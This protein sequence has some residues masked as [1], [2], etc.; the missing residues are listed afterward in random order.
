[1]AEKNDGGDKTEKPTPKRLSDAR[2]KGDVPKSKDVTSTVVL[3]AW[4]LLGLMVA[5]VTLDRLGGLFDEIFAVI[6]RPFAQAWPIAGAAAGRALVT[7]TATLLIPAAI[8]GM[9][10]EFA[11]VGPVFTLEKMTPKM[12]H[13]NPGEGLKRM[14]NTDNLFEVVKSLAKTVLLVVLTWIVAAAAFD[15]LMAVPTGEADGALAA[16]GGLTFQLLAGTVGVFLF[17]SM[18]DYAYQKF[19]FTKKMRMSRRDIRQEMKDSE[20]DPHVKAHRRQ[21]HQ[22]WAQQNAVQAARDASVLVVNPTHIACALAYDPAEHAVPVLLGK[23]EGLIAQAMREAAEA[24]GVPIIRNV[25]LARALR[26][27]VA[28]D[29]IIPQD[30]F[31]AVAEVILWAR[32]LR[33][34]AASNEPSPA[35]L[36]ADQDGAE[37]GPTFPPPPEGGLRPDQEP[38]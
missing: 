8:V 16:Y 26:D 6:D 2:K 29:D 21:L 32:R 36:P 1:M 20:G 14:F 13:M 23:G 22:E 37:S 17:V 19:S 31:A 24:Q 27:K 15:K 10:A 28:V 4:V 3:S 9:L 25:E 18:L 5:G 7:I 38:S 33:E 30:L 35:E 11:Q 34:D 12:S